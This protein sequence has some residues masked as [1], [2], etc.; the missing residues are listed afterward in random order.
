MNQGSFIDIEITDPNGATQ[1]MGMGFLGAIVVGLFVG[2]L[3]HFAK[4]I[5]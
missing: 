1:Q 2:Y 5:R 4:M 3:V